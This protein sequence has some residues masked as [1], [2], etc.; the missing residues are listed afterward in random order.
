MSCVEPG[1]VEQPR[2]S[3]TPATVLACLAPRG[4]ATAATA[5]STAAGT[6][7]L[8]T[9]GVAPPSSAAGAPRQTDEPGRG[10]RF[11][12]RVRLGDTWY[13]ALQ[14]KVTK[15]FPTVWI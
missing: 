8:G 6:R 2:R 1:G 12:G 10:R 4:R 15:R 7:W 14:I 11:G 13:D 9:R 5:N 3:D